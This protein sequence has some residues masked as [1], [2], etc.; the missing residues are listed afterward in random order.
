MIRVYSS[1]DLKAVYAVKALLEQNGIWAYIFNEKVSQM[2]GTLFNATPG[3]WPEVQIADEGRASDAK[4]LISAF[5]SDQRLAKSRPDLPPWK[6]HKCK[7][8]NDNS[9]E[10]CW[11]CGTPR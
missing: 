8:E 2:P 3:A 4:A 9:F 6:C 1:P 11:K 5:E 7:E 10:I